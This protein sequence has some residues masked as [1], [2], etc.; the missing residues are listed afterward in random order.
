MQECD[1]I[2]ESKQV[3]HHIYGEWEAVACVKCNNPKKK[4]KEKKRKMQ[5]KHHNVICKNVREKK[6]S[7]KP[8]V[9]IFWKSPTKS[10][11]VAPHFFK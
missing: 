1:N 5:P 7:I 8:S 6:W 3:I 4:K 10:P 2:N 11:A 9:W